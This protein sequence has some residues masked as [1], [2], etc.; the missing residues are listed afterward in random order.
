MGLLGGRLSP[1]WIWGSELEKQNHGGDLGP[2]RTC[3]ESHRFQWQGWARGHPPTW[4]ISGIA[5]EGGGVPV[6]WSGLGGGLIT[7]VTALTSA[8]PATLWFSEDGGLCLVPP[9][10]CTSYVLCLGHS[11]IFLDLGPPSTSFSTQ[12]SVPPGNLRWSLARAEAPLDGEA[13]R[14]GMVGVAE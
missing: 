7:P 2:E 1:N 8:S 10:A 4:M 6:L 13:R 5:G 3:L 12:L 14:A 9:V 11:A